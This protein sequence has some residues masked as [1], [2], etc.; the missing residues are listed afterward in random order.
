MIFHS[1][2]QVK[3][4]QAFQVECSQNQQQ[5]PS[6]FTFNYFIRLVARL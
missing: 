3:N 6:D 5:I 4:V 2:S 1:D